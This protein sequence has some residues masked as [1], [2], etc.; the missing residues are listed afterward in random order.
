MYYSITLYKNEDF[1]WGATEMGLWV[2]VEICCGFLVACIPVFPRFFKQQ[3]VLVSLRSSLRSLFRLKNSSYAKY[4]EGMSAENESAKLRKHTM[5][6]DIEFEDLV[7]RTDMSM[8]TVEHSGPRR[9]DS[10]TAGITNYD[11]AS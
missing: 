3:P 5:V 6:T 2:P 1:T 10:D 11:G 7:K 9:R 8:V 4:S